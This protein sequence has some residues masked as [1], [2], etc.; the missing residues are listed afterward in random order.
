LRIIVAIL[1]AFSSQR[2]CSAVSLW[3]STTGCTSRKITKAIVIYRPKGSVYS[4]GQKT[5]GA[6]DY[7]CQ[8]RHRF[9]VPLFVG[10]WLFLYA[11]GQKTINMEDLKIAVKELSFENVRAHGRLIVA[12]WRQKRTAV[13]T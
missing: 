13:L 5:T 2:C 7:V 10:L 12:C 8:Y 3:G 4:N 6:A 1:T 9:C 11:S